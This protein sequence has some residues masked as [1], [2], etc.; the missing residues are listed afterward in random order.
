M[1]SHVISLNKLRVPDDYADTFRVIGEAAGFDTGFLQTLI[2]MARFRNRLVH[3]YW[4]VDNDVIY[5]VLPG[6]VDNMEQFIRTF[7][8]SLSDEEEARAGSDSI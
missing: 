8:A 5:D 7:I 6:H 3:I 4:E 1:C 2:K